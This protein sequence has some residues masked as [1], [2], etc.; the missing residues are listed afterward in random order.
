MNKS[1]LEY[2]GQQIDFVPT[3]A[4]EVMV[5][6]TE[7]AKAFGKR[8]DNF[9]RLAQTK[10]YIRILEKFLKNQAKL[11]PN[12]GSSP[13][14]NHPKSAGDLTHF[15]VSSGQKSMYTINGVGTYFHR[16]LALK[17][18]AWLSPE[19]ELWVFATID[20]VLYG[21]YREWQKAEQQKLDAQLR[22]EQ[23]REELLKTYP[24]LESFLEMESAVKEMNRVAARRLS[25]IKNQ[26]KLE[27]NDW[28]PP[29]MQTLENNQTLAIERRLRRIAEDAN[30]EI[31]FPG[32]SV[33]KESKKDKNQKS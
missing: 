16:L 28:K 9:L 26:L 7:M 15:R 6:A 10:E 20:T 29:K 8:P 5:N 30:R 3:T 18:A 13:I 17:F 11:T 12:G 4:N 22:L 33:S 31:P 1:K 19:F 23:K 24:E 2:N 27:F 21:G 14:E 32:R 25:E